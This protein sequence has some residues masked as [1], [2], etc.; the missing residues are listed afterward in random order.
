MKLRKLF[1]KKI[2]TNEVNNDIID[3]SSDGDVSIISERENEKMSKEVTKDE[4]KLE[5]KLEHR[6]VEAYSEGSPILLIS[7]S[8]KIPQRLA[9]DILRKYKE[10]SR[11][12]RTF[13]DDFKKMVA[14]RDMNGVPR[15]T[16]AEELQ[17][18]V[19]TVKK[20][21]E[22]FGQAIK[23]KAT[24]DQVFTKIEGEF[25]LKVCP[26]CGSN[27]NNLVDEKTTYCMNCD[28]EHEYYDGYV[29]KI[30]FEYLEE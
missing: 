8:F 1:S 19:N 13:T 26:S 14:E 18:N 2:L 4:Q 11:L 25:D 10:E 30:N 29:L 23:E 24:S 6:V 20:A 22:Q 12:K 5:K 27:K 21:C 17:L 7:E 28:T 9:L 15:S 16:I 3:I